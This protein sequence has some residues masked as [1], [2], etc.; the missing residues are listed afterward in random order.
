VPKA[1]DDL[2]D[3]EIPV[4]TTNEFLGTSTFTFLR[5]WSRAPRTRTKL[6]EVSLTM[7]AGGEREMMSH[8]SVP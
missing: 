2:P 4:N 1:S 6:S 3:P 8:R 7:R 5:L